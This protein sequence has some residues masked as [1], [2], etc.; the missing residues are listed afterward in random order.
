MLSPSNPSAENLVDNLVH[1]AES[2]VVDP[3]G[4]SPFKNSDKNVVILELSITD[5]LELIQQTVFHRFD[6]LKSSTQMGIDI[7]VTVKKY[8]YELT[9]GA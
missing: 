5:D 8:I 6:L 7:F 2:Y 1:N 4:P 3:E 9:S